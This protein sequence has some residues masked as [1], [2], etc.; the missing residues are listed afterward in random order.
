VETEMISTGLPGLD[1]ILKGG[2]RKGSAVLITG[3]PGTGKTIIGIQ[4]IIEGAKRNEPGIYIT[5]EE[6][7]ENIR[8]YASSL[9]LDI[10]GYEKKGL[11]TLIKQPLAPKKLM[12]IAA[13]LNIIKSKKIKRV[14]LDS[15]TLFKYAYYPE[16]VSYRREVLN[17]IIRMKESG[18]TSLSISEK[19]LTQIDDIN[20]G[21][22]DFLFDGLIL[23]TKIRKSSTYE[24]CIMV[25]KMRGQDHLV[26]IFPY[27]IGQGGV[28]VFPDQLPFSLIEKD[29]ERFKK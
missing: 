8:L 9:G 2:I 12:S 5:S 18:T 4:Y 11:I 20:Y 10:T 22:E 13:P 29:T 25:S 23:L 14:V 21:A 6:V 27:K 7:T 26:D 17:F 24:H 16:E 15:L 28:T 3:S 19:S 1:K